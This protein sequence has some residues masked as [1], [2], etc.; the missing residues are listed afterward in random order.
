MGGK[1]KM[2]KSS[3]GITLIALIITVIVLLILAGTAILMSLN[4][5]LLLEHTN[6]ASVEYSS[7]VKEEESSIGEYVEYME[8]R[9]WNDPAIEYGYADKEGVVNARELVE[10]DIIN[11]YYDKDKEPISCAVL[12][13]DSEHGLQVV[14]LRCDTRLR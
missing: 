3:N 8:L 12:Y 14:S 10:G 5:G 6:S 9:T 7:K 2:M 4:S 13:N 1:Q 11:Y